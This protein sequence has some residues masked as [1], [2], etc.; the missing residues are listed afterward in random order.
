MPEF[1]AGVLGFFFPLNG[2]IPFS[3]D[4]TVDDLVC[5]PL[6]FFG[7]KLCKRSKNGLSPAPRRQ[8]EN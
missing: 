5:V 3:R 2:D 8:L 4:M 7:C 1:L 6:C